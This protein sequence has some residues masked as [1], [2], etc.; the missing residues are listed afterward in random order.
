MR[1]G[2]ANGDSF[3][4]GYG[5]HISRLAD[6]LV[7]A[8]QPFERIHLGNARLLERAVKFHDSDFVAMPQ[9]TVEDASDREATLEK[10]RRAAL[11]AQRYTYDRAIASYR[12]VLN[13][14][15]SNRP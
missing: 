11:A 9:R 5:E 7:Y 6:G 3:H 8:L 15:M 2:F 13:D 14:V 12:Q 10:G 1:D 4:P